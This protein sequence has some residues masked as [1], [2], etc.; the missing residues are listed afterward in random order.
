MQPAHVFCSRTS[1]EAVSYNPQIWPFLA[2]ACVLDVSLHRVPAA[3]V[4]SIPSSILNA[5]PESAT[6]LLHK[7]DMCASTSVSPR[8]KVLGEKEK[9]YCV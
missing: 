5:R 9:T 1:S 4:S 3:V 6:Y 2:G 8:V 7:E